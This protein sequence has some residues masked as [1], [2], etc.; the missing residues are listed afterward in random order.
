MQSPLS[1]NYGIQSLIGEAVPLDHLHRLDTTVTPLPIDFRVPHSFFE[2]LAAWE[3]DHASA[4]RI[5][6]CKD[7]VPG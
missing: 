2:K 3:V 5:A 1:G 4:Q 7:H 6:D